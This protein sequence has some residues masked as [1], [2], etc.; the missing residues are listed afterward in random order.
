VLF[1]D[2]QTLEFF[3]YQ[4]VWCYFIIY[5]SFVPCSFLHLYLLEQQRISPA[6]LLKLDIRKAFDSVSWEYILDLLQRRGFPHRFRN[7]IAALF[8]T[9]TSRVLL[10][11][12]AGPPIAHGRGLRQGDPLSPLLFV[13]AIDPISQILEEATCVGLLHKLRGRGAIL[14]TSLYADDAAV[15][16]APIKS[17]VQNIAGILQ[18]FGEVTGLCTNFLKSSVVAIRCANIDS[19]EVLEDMPATRASFP[20]KYLGLPLSVWRL[21]RRDFQHLEDKCAGKLPT[22]NGKMINMAGRVALVKLVLASQAIYHIT[23]LAIPPGTLKFINKLER[24]FVWAAKDTTSGAKCKVNWEAMCR[25][26][27]F[28]GLG[29]LHLD[30]FGTALRLWWPWLEWTSNDKI[31][32]GSGNPCT[33]NDMDIFYAATNITLG[34]GLKMPF[35]YAPWV[36]GRKP[37]DIAPKIFEI[38]KKKKWSVAQALHD[39][40][41]ISKLRNEVTL[42]IDH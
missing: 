28:G 20:L 29:I 3:V 36:H 34:N 23:P 14:H 42:S 38:C 22:W 9:A 19:D 5:G 26:K 30:K 13:L 27:V 21:R 24:A 17:D 25:P 8:S 37:K 10:N 18:N 16:I 33:A 12:I 11:G 41:W 4:S 35:W 1:Q 15:F 7:W 6:L 31:W 32:A 40:E 39:N 2:K